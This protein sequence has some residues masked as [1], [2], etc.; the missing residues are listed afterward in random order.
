MS[1]LRAVAFQWVNPKAWAMALTALSAYV[2]AESMLLV[3]MVAGLF[4]LINLPCIASWTVLGQQMRRFLTSPA[5]LRAFN[6]TMALGLV[7]TLAP[8][9][10]H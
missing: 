2:P 9:L 8:I 6:I 5:R 10:S 4:G 1:F 3:A 7:A